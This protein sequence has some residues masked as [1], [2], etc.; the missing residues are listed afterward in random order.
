MPA[1]LDDVLGYL[2]CP[3]C[4]KPL[5]RAS[6]SLPAR[7]SPARIVSCASGHSFDIARQGYL[8]LLPPGWHGGADTA[9]MVAARAGF[10]AR[11]HF[12]T[13]AAAVAQET[14][15]AVRHKQGC[16]IEVGAGT[17]Y[18]LS[19]ALDL[20]PASQGLALDASKYA[21]RR[22]AQAHQRIGAVGCDIWHGLP[23]A[24]G[25]ATALLDIFAPR[26]P[27]EFRRI[28]APQGTLIVV[29]P[30]PAHLRELAPLGLI[31]MDERKDTRITAALE[32]H[33][34]QETER[35]VTR[36]M[37]LSHQDASDAILMGPAARH[38]EPDQLRAA[39]AQL[40]SELAVTVSVTLSRWRCRTDHG[41]RRSAEGRGP[42]GAA[43]P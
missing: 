25:T 15:H 8:S 27:A 41:R 12:G 36:T 35:P 29:A 17:G 37:Y 9:E 28:L 16:V 33:F 6:Q 42:S 18:Y 7:A 21:L 26:N 20:L 19:A 5:S 31:G 13:L 22:A 40:P 30:N 38:I 4:G 10:L 14:A 24:D 2:R 43:S 23:V 39:L 34:T 3:H 1:V 32:P 11:G